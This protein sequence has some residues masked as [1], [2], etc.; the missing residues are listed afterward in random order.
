MTTTSLHVPIKI[1]VSSCLAGEAVRYDGGDRKNSII[2]TQFQHYF[3]CESIC[4]EVAIGLGVPRN[5][6]MITAG[7]TDK[8]GNFY[9][10]DKSDHNRNYTDR[11]LSYAKRQQ[12]HFEHLCGYVVKERSPSC[13][14]KMTPRFLKNDEV[15]ILGAGI[16]T[17]QIIFR[18]PWLP[19][20]SEAQLDDELSL[21]N[22]LERVFIL[23]FWNELCEKS[24]QVEIFYNMIKHQIEL[25]GKI[26]NSI[27]E[28]NS[29]A[30]SEIMTILKMPVTKEMH[31]QFLTSQL[32]NY[33]ITSNATMRALEYYKSGTGALL[34]VIKH[35]QTVF[36]NK[37]IELVS[38]YFYPDERE[39]MARE[40]IYG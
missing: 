32:K 4:P 14:F 8:S 34:D 6:I 15:V 26:F 30:I 17:E 29:N 31:S 7:D 9:L 5:P 24:E 16:F 28:I 22:F 21:D 38:N 13:G 11:M 1:A 36:E 35:F 2:T 25:R 10:V 23:H 12:N 27:R 40:F 3:S 18:I 19:I 37:N 33:R 20:I 39:I